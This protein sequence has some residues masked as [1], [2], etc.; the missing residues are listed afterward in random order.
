MSVGCVKVSMV[1]FQAAD[2]GSIPGR[3]M[4]LCRNSL[5]VYF[6]NYRNFDCRIQPTFNGNGLIYVPIDFDFHDFCCRCLHF[7]FVC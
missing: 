4:L 5:F 1:A 6:N 2:P 7:R 3:R